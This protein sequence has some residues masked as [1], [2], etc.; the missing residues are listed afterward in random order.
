[1]PSMCRTRLLFTLAMLACA[2]AQADFSGRVVAVP[3]G[4]TLDILCEGRATRVR[5]AGIDAPE[6]LQR[7]G[8]R[9]QSYL[10]T[11]AL[12]KQAMVEERGMDRNGY[13]VARVQVYGTDVGLR[14]IS[15]G[16]AWHLKGQGRIQNQTPEEASIYAVAESRAR[17]RHAGLWQDLNPLPPWE[18]RQLQQRIEPGGS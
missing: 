15:S 11:L 12:N 2:P 14:L 13:T 1:M 3:D 10:A 4:D 7:H 17:Q 16:M 5:I 8:A 9:A 18:W 6:L